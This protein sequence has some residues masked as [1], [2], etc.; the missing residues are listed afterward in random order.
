MKLYYGKIGENLIFLFL[1]LF[2]SEYQSFIR[3]IHNNFNP[4][5]NK[6]NK[7]NRMLV[8]TCQSR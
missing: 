3:L 2:S 4:K 1:F 8:S 5:L 6:Q 7:L